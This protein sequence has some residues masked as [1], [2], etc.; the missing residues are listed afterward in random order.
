MAARRTLTELEGCVLGLVWSGGPC[1]AYAIRKELLLSASPHWSGSAGAI[2]PL[3]GRL[4]RQGLIR[5][6][7]HATG[8][9]PSRMYEVT[10]AGLEALRAWIGPPLSPTVVGI[11]PD[12]LRTRLYFLEALPPRCRRQ[13]LSEAERKVRAELARSQKQAH[14]TR[15]E[16]LMT[17]LA[18]RG[19]VLSMAARLEWIREIR[20]RGIR[21][22]GA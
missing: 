1:T 20:V 16:N 22:D 11:P 13:L 14:R 17:F 10:A 21:P 6:R 18:D 2:Y 4:A 19:A 9:R 7:P 8:R 12:P 3:M 5:S 15:D